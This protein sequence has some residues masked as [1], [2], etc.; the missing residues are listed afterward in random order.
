MPHTASLLLLYPASLAKR[1][2]LTNS[3]D[4][5]PVHYVF[6]RRSLDVFVAGVSLAEAS[7]SELE[8]G[9][10]GVVVVWDVAYDH[11]ASELISALRL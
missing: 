11:A 1:R 8:S 4:A 10:K 9:R 2:A 3:T 7:K 5:I 6:P